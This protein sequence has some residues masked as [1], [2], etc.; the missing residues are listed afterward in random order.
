MLS[1]D[2]DYSPFYPCKL[3]FIVNN[4]SSMT[5]FQNLIFVLLLS[6]S[7]LLSTVSSFSNDV[8]TRNTNYLSRSTATTNTQLHVDFLKSL[9]SQPSSSSSTEVQ[10]LK[11]ELYTIC[12]TSYGKSTPQ[13]K[14]QIQSLITQLSQSNPTRNTATSNL[15]QR[16]WIVLWTSE[17]EINWF[18]DNGISTCITQTLSGGTRLE[19]WILFTNGGGF[20]VVGTISVDDNDAVS[21]NSVEKGGNNNIIR[22]QFKFN[23]AK[24]D[25]GK[26]GTYNFPP[27]GNGWFDTVYLDEELRIDLNSRDDI[28]I[29]KSSL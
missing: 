17:K 9:F 24:L 5:I 2:E 16:E 13:I 1:A 27:I 21:S 8:L 26:W 29:C 7:T 3:P 14:S 20:G 28:L 10:N 11:Q 6:S 15:L 4:T 19:N 25:L 23:S 22:T 18:I 12:N